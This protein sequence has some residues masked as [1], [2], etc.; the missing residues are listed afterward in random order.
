M[1]QF[2]S[3]ASPA[4]ASRLYR[5]VVNLKMRISLEWSR[6]EE[7]GGRLNEDCMDYVTCCKL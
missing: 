6:H 1:L 3:S 5:V 2:C 7:S 4:P